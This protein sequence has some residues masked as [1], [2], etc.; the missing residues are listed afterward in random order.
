[1][2]TCCNNRVGSN[3]RVMWMMDQKTEKESAGKVSLFIDWRFKREKREREREESENQ[4][5]LLDVL[6]VNGNEI[7]WSTV[8]K[9]FYWRWNWLYLL[10]WFESNQMMIRKMVGG[11]G[12][13]IRTHVMEWGEQ[14]EER[15]SYFLKQGLDNSQVNK[16]LKSSW[17]KK[18]TNHFPSFWLYWRMEMKFSYIKKGKDGRNE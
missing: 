2:H 5:N 10:P 9:R 12:D 14:E 8:Y 13:H 3:R 7:R 16:R 17:R 11:D 15:S 18:F 6:S 4:I 1:M